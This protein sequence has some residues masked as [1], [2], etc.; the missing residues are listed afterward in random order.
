MPRGDRAERQRRRVQ[1]AIK[2][3]SYCVLATSSASNRP[4]VAG[5]LYSL[6]DGALFVATL[7]GSVKVRNIRENERVAVC[8]PVRRFPVGPPFAMQF[9]GRAEVLAVGDLPVARALEAGRLRRITS[10]GELDHPDTC[11]LRIAPGARVAT[12]GLG[13]PL[14]RLLRDPLGASGGVTLP[15]G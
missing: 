8:I 14:L 7:A 9:Q 11:V 1:R 4:H 12:Y 3:H 5:V 13:V 15:V 2:R 6:V 10:H